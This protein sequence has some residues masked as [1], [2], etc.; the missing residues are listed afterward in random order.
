MHSMMLFMLSLKTHKVNYWKHKNGTPPWQKLFSRKKERNRMGERLE[1]GSY[2]DMS[3]L[4]LT[5]KKIHSKYDK[6]LRFA[7]AEWF[8]L[9]YSIYLK[10]WT[11]LKKNRKRKGQVIFFI[12][13]V[14]SNQD[15][16]S[17]SQAWLQTSFMS[18]HFSNLLMKT[19]ANQP[20]PM[21]SMLMQSSELNLNKI[22]ISLYNVSCYLPHLITFWV[23]TSS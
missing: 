21:Y 20:N 1:T 15:L 8:L 18:F 19:Q 13:Q 5:E 4:F 3:V 10:H 6:T 9:Y 17:S 22:L 7:E 16:S 11:I 12:S 23:L 2:I 14:R